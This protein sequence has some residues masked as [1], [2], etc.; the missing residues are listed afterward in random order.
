MGSKKA[1]GIS[2]LMEFVS[3]AGLCLFAGYLLIGELQ[4]QKKCIPD[5]NGQAR[6]SC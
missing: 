1:K 5:P 6:S 4:T 2:D 3:L